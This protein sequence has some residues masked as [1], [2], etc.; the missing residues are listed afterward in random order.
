MFT[1][2]DD[3][4]SRALRY[5]DCYGQRFMRAGTY[6][7]NVLPTGGRNLTDDRPFII[8]VKERKGEASMKQHNVVLSW[9]ENEFKPDRPEISVEVGNLVMWNCT[10]PA[11]PPYEVA[12]AKDFF[13]SSNLVN[14]CGF[15]HA[16][17]HAGQYEWA[18][19]NGSGIGGVVRVKDPGCENQ[20]DIAR[21][22]SRLAKGTLVMVANG[23]ADPATVEV[24][25]GQTVF[26]AIVA[27][28]GITVTDRRLHAL[29]NCHPQG[30]SSGKAG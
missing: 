25:V 19:A 17:G 18:D 1:K 22:H 10:S 29:G 16:F 13:G 7:Y 12:G 20:A 14:E 11:A 26:F 24:E 8:Q 21:W 6:N 30:G 4:D 9:S 15:S 27:S 3:L 5:T 23:K 28:K 2:Q